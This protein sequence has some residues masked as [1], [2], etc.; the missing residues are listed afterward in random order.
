MGVRVL[1]ATGIVPGDLA[2]FRDGALVV[3][4]AGTVLDLGPA[5][6]LLPRHTGAPVERLEGVIFP[7]LVNAH[8]H[9]ELTGLAGSAGPGLGFAAWADRMIAARFTTP[10]EALREATEAAVASLEGLATVAVGDVGNGLS[11]VPALARHRIAGALFH[12]VFGSSR[13]AA[14]GKVSAIESEAAAH[15]ASF[16]YG[17]RWSPSAHTL[18][19]THADAVRALLALA[20]RVGSRSSLHLAEHASEREALVH[21]RG[22]MVD[23]LAS[24][25]VPVGALH[26]PGK[27]PIAYA[28]ELGALA[29]D[30]LLVHLA[31]ATPEELDLVAERGAH[32]VVCPRSNAWI[33]G[34]APDLRAMIARGIAPA[35]GTDSRV[36]SPSL[37]VLDEARAARALAPELS[38]DQVLRMATW[39]G[40]RALD[41]PLN[42]RFAKGSRPG[43]FLLPGDF[44][45]SPSARLLDSVGAPRVRQDRTLREPE[46]P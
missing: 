33:E 23:F 34:N 35:L 32:V 41:L 20:R 14:L 27:G 25:G 5:N 15:R 31:D 19:T 13:E 4:D 26:W 6:E 12:E 1:H 18:H 9:L 43:I 21:G 30:V 10:A 17:L 46:A 45:G 39:N 3:D 29:E 24:K 38:A 37:D 11:S 16:E 22:K 8:T 36:S 44:E 28:D 2:S 42:G 7:G 40:A